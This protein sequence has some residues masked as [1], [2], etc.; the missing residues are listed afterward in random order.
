VPPE[1]A[2]KISVLDRQVVA[3]QPVIASEKR[4]YCSH[5]DELAV[6]I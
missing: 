6:E 4:Y 2:M 3:L 1:F 5:G